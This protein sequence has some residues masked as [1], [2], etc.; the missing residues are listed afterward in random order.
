MKALLWTV[1]LIAL[2]VNVSTSFVFD[3]AQQALIS[4]GTGVLA[5]G[6]G[7]TIYLTRRRDA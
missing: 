7:V 2:A 5:L 3:G 6:T 1:L 4:V